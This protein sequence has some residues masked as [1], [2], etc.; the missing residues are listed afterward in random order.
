LT[1]VLC[2]ALVLAACAGAPQTP[3]KVKI[4][5]S[6]P[7]EIVATTLEPAMQMAMDEHN[8]MAGNVEV[9]LMYI[10]SADGDNYFSPEKDR[11]AAEKAVADPAVVAYLGPVSSEQAKQSIPVLNQA[12]M[13]QITIDATWPGL[14]KPGF[15]PGEPGIYYPT[16]KQTFFRLSPTDDV[17]GKASAVF[18]GQLGVESV[19]L[20]DDQTAYS[21]GNV[22]VFELKAT[23][24]GIQ[25][26]EHESS[27]DYNTDGFDFG[28]LAQRI[29]DA[30]PDVV[31]WAFTND[32]NTARLMVAIRELD[33]EFPI[34]GTEFNDA[35]ITYFP[36][37]GL[38][39]S[40]LDGIY[41]SASGIPLDKQYA[42]ES[43]LA[44][45]EKYE[46][47]YETPV[48]HPAA[49]IC[50]EAI[51]VLLQAI[52]QADRPTR[53]GVLQALWDM[54]EYTGALGTWSFTDS[55]DNSIVVA[56]ISRL[57]NGEFVTVKA[58]QE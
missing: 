29:V 15:A 30:D 5:I 17:V 22:G 54:G 52:E 7:V 44:F 10:D 1:V 24:L 12:G 6:V 11:E 3:G 39:V 47:K 25:V 42:S 55:G 46:A 9:E 23:D 8:G 43:I 45:I 21:V 36:D 50:Y 37:L 26:I 27:A 34:M 57:E 14:T 20:V 16:G 53:A 33:P 48:P 35:V 58:I 56:T 41:S 28:P 49:V 32:D 4:A 18:A 40:M 51:G 13:A 2:V 31:Y 38:D 19:Y